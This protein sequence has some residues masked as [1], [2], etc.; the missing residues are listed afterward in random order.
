MNVRR[1]F[2][3]A[4]V[5]KVCQGNNAS[6]LQLW[7]DEHTRQPLTFTDTQID[8]LGQLLP[9]LLCG[10]QS[11][12]LVFNQEIARLQSVQQQLSPLATNSQQQRLIQSLIEVESDECRHDIALQSVADQLP[13]LDGFIKVQ[14]QAKRFY[15]RLGRV[16]NFSEH[17][18]RIAVLDTCV[19]QIMH[20]FESCKLGPQHGFSQLCGLI[21]KDEAKHVYISRGHAIALGAQTE[22]FQQ[23]QWQVSRAL[24]ELLNTQ[25]QAFESMGICLDDIRQK[26]EDKWQ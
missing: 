7:L 16:D 20:A 18:V 19:T 5:P 2:A 24:F 26:L 23:Q 8:N 6:R 4:T 3:Q 11:A 17:F 13:T 10:E 9:L 22:D 14:R 25:H 21:K 15:S 1:C 12:Q